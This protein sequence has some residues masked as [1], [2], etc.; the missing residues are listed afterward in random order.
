MNHQAF[1]L[2]QAR[3]LLVGF[4]AEWYRMARG[5][6][7]QTR[8]ER[9]AFD[10]LQGEYLQ[11]EAYAAIG[12]ALDCLVPEGNMSNNSDEALSSAQAA[13][14]LEL[15]R[16]GSGG[17]FD[18]HVMSQLF[19]R[20]LIEVRSSDRRVALTQHGQRLFNELSGPP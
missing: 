2:V 14:I 20:G 18:Q 17:H 7:C 9:L 3:P 4:M 19:A 16:S 11:S 1:H 12:I 13:A 8:I 6:G 15:G 10:L 5:F